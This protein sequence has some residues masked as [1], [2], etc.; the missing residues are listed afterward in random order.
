M[1]LVLNITKFQKEKK[2]KKSIEKLFFNKQSS[3]LEIQINSK[4]KL[5]SQDHQND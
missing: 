3:F 2:F 4:T 1:D 5:I